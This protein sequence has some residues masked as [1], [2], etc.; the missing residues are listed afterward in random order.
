MQC[1]G[2]G[3]I[4]PVQMVESSLREKEMHD[5]KLLGDHELESAEVI[6]RGSSAVRATARARAWSNV[7]AI[8]GFCVAGLICSMFVPASYLHIEQTSALIAQAP[9]S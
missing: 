9:L 6:V 8:V 7:W 3:P 4:K 1:F 5:R 2:S